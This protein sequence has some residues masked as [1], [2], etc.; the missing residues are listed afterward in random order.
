M[1]KLRQLLRKR[2]GPK[3]NTTPSAFFQNAAP[4]AS[5]ESVGATFFGPATRQVQPK[6]QIN[7][8]GDIYEKQA[9]AMAERV[10]SKGKPVQSTLV[11]APKSAQRQGKEEIQRAS[12]PKEVQKMAQPKEEKTVQKMSAPEEPRRKEK[13]E[14]QRKPEEEQAVQKKEEEVKCKPEEEKIQTMP[15]A[16]GA[17]AAPSGFAANLNRSKGQGSGLGK[18]ALN[19]MSSAF[20]RDFSGV[21]IHTDSHAEQLSEQ[22]RAQ[23]FTHG[24]DIYFNQ[25]KYS[26][27][28]QEGKRLLAHEL[29]HVVQQGALENALKIQRQDVEEFSTPIPEDFTVAR[30]RRGR[31]TRASGLVGGA[32]VVINPDQVGKIRKGSSGVT[33]VGLD[34]TE[35]SANYSP[36]V[37][38]IRESVI[39]MTIGTTYLQGVDKQSPSEYGRGTTLGDQA[40]GNVSLRFHEGSHGTLA[41]EFIRNNPLPQF[42]GAIGMTIAEYKAAIT[43]FNQEMTD[44]LQQLKKAQKQ[45]VDCVGS[46]A[47]FCNQ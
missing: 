38:S 13:E 17:G 31:A 30:D 4:E 36:T 14:V 12:Q 43:Q 28:T 23:A 3:G 20:G 41:M 24:K 1:A 18:G 42:S 25:G 35:P 15:S 39:T 44:Y 16:N 19:E 29:T 32:N 45:E 46:A 22:I 7:Q 37:S 11:S 27:E 33:N 9:D 10:V 40:S 6:L 26:P 8:P 21:R 2:R 34:W 5:A 47:P